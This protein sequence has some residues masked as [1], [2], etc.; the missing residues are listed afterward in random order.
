M[1]DTF[2]PVAPN[3]S[4]SYAPMLIGVFFNMILY[5]ILV[6]QVLQYYTTYREDRLWM[7]LFV[8]YLFVVETCNTGFDMHIMYEP[9]ILRFGKPTATKFFPTLFVTEP[10]CITLVSTP[11]Q[12]FFA[13]RIKTI[14]KSVWIPSIISVLAFTSLAGGLWTSAKLVIIK[15]FVRKP[16]LHTSAL[17]WFLASCVADV[18]ITGTLVLSLT[19]RKT[20]FVATDTVIDKIIRMTVQTGA[21]TSLFAIGDVLFFMLIPGA[22]NF[23]WDLSLA[24]L[25]TNCLMSTLN[26]RA[27]LNDTTQMPSVR[28]NLTQESSGRRMDASFLEGG[29][30]LHF[31]P[32]S[33][34]SPG[35]FELEQ[36]SFEAGVK[37][38]RVVERLEDSPPSRKSEWGYQ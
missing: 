18:L 36:K 34:K 29:Q 20:G 21:I 33:P 17:I 7:K 23:I 35:A 30:S 31:H 25:Y 1:P 6:M 27:T 2:T 15:V 37:V 4:H 19:K 22:F 26:A 9:L 5:G 13:W 14:T 3:L 32:Q 12:L 16:E 8:A 11:I 38:T 10:L 28:R 24:K